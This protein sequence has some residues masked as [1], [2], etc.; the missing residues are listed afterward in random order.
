MAAQQKWEKYTYFLVAYLLS[1][2]VDWASILVPTNI[3]TD[4]ASISEEG[5]PTENTPL[6]SHW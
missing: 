6:S 1:P 3:R 2:A 5:A 4:V